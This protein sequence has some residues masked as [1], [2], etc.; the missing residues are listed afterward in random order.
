[1]KVGLPQTSRVIA[2]WNGASDIPASVEE[3]LL[4]DVLWGAGNQARFGD[5]V[6][7]LNADQPGFRSLMA[8]TQRAATS[9][10]ANTLPLLKLGEIDARWSD[11]RYWQ[12]IRRD[13]H[14]LTGNNLLAALDLH[15]TPTGDIESLPEGT[16][17][18]RVIIGRTFVVSFLVTMICIL[19]GV[20]Y[21]L[22][23]AKANGWVRSLML[24]MVLIPLWTSLLVRSAAWVVILQDR[25]V[26]NDVL[27]AAGAIDH[28]LQLIYN[29]TGVLVA[30]SQVLCPFMVLP[31]YSAIRA[32][33]A[34][35]MPAAASL[36]ARPFTAFVKVLLPLIVPGIVSGA[37]LV[38]MSALGYYI[39]PTLVGGAGDQM[40]SSVIAF[41][42]TGTADWG[43]AAALG[44]IL[45][46]S[47]LV[48][49][50]AYARV[51]KTNV[52]MGD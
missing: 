2:T 9:A 10:D 23:A 35:L 43:R 46:C 3:A 32:V 20:P 27:R 11:R 8:K 28:P 25:G 7:Q 4:K 52:L 41:Y 50:V 30:M 26:V 48:L 6:R 5:A 31:V 12:T 17:A 19:I 49:Y 39:T 36:G 45:L 33:P 15:R 1:M 29:R 18:N 14:A 21:A 34:S 40:I 38:F 37:L 22:I 16:S 44:L 13:A 24:V 47:T 51:S 42:A